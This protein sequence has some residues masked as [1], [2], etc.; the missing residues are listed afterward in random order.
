MTPE[1]RLQHHDQA[2][3]RQSPGA[4]DLQAGDLV[5]TGTCT[6]G[7]FSGPLGSQEARMR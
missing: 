4:G 1:Q 6:G 3:W 2:R 7:Q 5:T